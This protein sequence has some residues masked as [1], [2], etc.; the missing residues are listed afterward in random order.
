MVQLTIEVPED[1]ADRLQPVRNRMADILE[2]GLR[3]IEPLNQPLYNELIEF[4]SRGPRPQEILAF[5]PSA[6]VNERISILLDKNQSGSLNASEQA[7]LE[8]AEQLDYLMTLI[9]V[10]V[11]QHLAQPQ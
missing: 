2:L 9:K 4:L 8:Q 11:R 1:L 3:D 6:V 5:R 10:R 7:E